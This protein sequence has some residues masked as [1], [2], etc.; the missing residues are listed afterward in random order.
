MFTDYGSIQVLTKK[1]FALNG[2]AKQRNGTLLA[3]VVVQIM[4]KCNYVSN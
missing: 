2:E 4:Y 1:Q 3:E